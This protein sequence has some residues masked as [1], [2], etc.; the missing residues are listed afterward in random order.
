MF[1]VKLAEY[2]LNLLAG[3]LGLLGC[4]EA[5]PKLPS[6]VIHLTVRPLGSVDAPPMIDVIIDPGRLPPCGFG[7]V[8]HMSHGT[9]LIETVANGSRR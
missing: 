3:L 4:T 5:V 6:L 8:A 1:L 2:F 7:E 9:H